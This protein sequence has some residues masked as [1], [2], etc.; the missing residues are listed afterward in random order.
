MKSAIFY[1]SSTGNTENA[2]KQIREE[3]GG[4]E[5]IGLFDISISGIDKIKEYNKL[6]IGVSTWGE[7]D[8]QDDWD[9]IFEEFKNIDFSNKTVAFF[10]LGDQESYSDEYVDAMATLYEVVAQEK[11]ANIIG[12]WPI[13]EY[14]FDESRAVVD[15]E[16][17]GLALDEDNQSNLTQDRIK[18][19]CLQIKEQIL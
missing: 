6:I 2:A 7:G 19:W 11:S 10:G 15:G 5:V 18:T 3:L 17:V 13:D 12:K 9:D 4:K 1:G 14:E 16:F 8:L